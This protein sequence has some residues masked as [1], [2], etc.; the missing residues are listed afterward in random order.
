MMLLELHIFL[1]FKAAFYSIETLVA[2]VV[3]SICAK[4]RHSSHLTIGLSRHVA[5]F[6]VCII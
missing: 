1:M 2:H 6:K 4:M 3:N 5:T